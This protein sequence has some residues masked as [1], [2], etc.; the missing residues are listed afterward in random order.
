[1]GISAE[2]KIFVMDANNHVS[3]EQA[4]ILQDRLHL[5]NTM[6]IPV[7][8]AGEIVGILGI[9]NRA[10][11]FSYTQDDQT[12]FDVFAKQTTIAL[13][14]EKLL[15]RVEKLEIKD[16]L[17]GLY[18][19]AYILNYLGEEIKRAVRFQRPCAFMLISIDRFDK[20]EASLGVEQTNAIIIKIAALIRDFVREVDRVARFDR[21]TFAVVL[22]EKN[23]REMQRM[24]QELKEKIESNFASK[25]D[26]NKLL[27]VSLGTSE[28][29]LDGANADELVACA[30]KMSYH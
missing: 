14:N 1:M 23:K 27:T 6:A 12:L 11:G 25:L 26:H 21:N 9:G 19:Q 24:A 16:N 30:Q 2:D 4:A 10:E 20:L 5:R 28:N 3:A 7:Y 8:L 22:P 15:R 29:P 13:G 17:T 18:N